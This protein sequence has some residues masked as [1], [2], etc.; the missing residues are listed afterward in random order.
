M[1]SVLY[2]IVLVCSGNVPLHDCNTSTAR[3]VVPVQMPEGIISCGIP[4]VFH[5][6]AGTAIAPDETEYTKTR[7]ELRQKAK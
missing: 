6:L 1:K 4:A 2:A 7:C 3:A 5:R